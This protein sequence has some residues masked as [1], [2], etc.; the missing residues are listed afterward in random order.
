V[1]GAVLAHE[2]THELLASRGIWLQDQ[3]ENE[4][5]TDLAC[6]SLGAGKLVLNGSVLA[7][8]P[9]SDV[10]VGYLPLD[11]RCMAYLDVGRRLHLGIEQ[12]TYGLTEAAQTLVM[13]TARVH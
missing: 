4:L 9:R 2:L 6:I 13:K 10:V 3:T 8:G 5:L 12:L 11:L 7:A 1:L